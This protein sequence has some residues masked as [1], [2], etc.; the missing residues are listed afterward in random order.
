MK[1]FNKPEDKK[2]DLKR[3]VTDTSAIISG[4][5]RE[6]I[7]SGK[8]KN[9]E[10]IIPEIVMGELQAQTSRMRESGFLGLEEIKKIR[11]LTKKHKITL[12]F[13]G[14]RPSYED[15]LLAKSGR[16][17]AL[18]QDIAKQN[19]AVLITCDLPQALVAEA[20]GI[21]V[22][23]FESYKK[24]K[25][26]KIEKMLTNDTLSLHLKENAIPYAKKGKPGKIE[27]VKLKEK[28]MEAE[29]L[30]E[31]SN[32]IFEAARFEQNAFMEIGERSA[33]V[34]QLKDMRIAI[35]RPP[36][37]DG[38]EITVV[39]PIIKLNLNDYKLSKKLKER[40]D[41][42]V[43]GMLIAGP[44]GSGKSTLAASVAEF[45]MKNNNAIVKTM[46]SPRDL[47]LPNEITQ[48]APLDGSFIKTSDILLLVRP[49]YTIFDEVRK[50]KDF[51]V[52]ADMRLAGI[53]M[54]GVVHSTD[55]ISAVQ[56]FIG[57]IELGVIPHIVDTIL[58]VKDG[59]IKKVYS[60]SLT[61][62][63]PQGM[64]EADLA[65]PIVEVKDFETGK[66]EYEIYT[67]GEQTVVI[68]A[69][70]NGKKSGVERLALDKIKS[71][72]YK[73]D[74]KA[75]VE[76]LSANKISV[77]VR[78]DVI[79]Y[80]IGKEG[81]TIKNLED[82]LGISI[83]IEPAVESLG[84]E[85]ERNISETGGYLVFEFPK[86]HSGKNVNIYID[87]GYLFTATIGRSDQIKVSKKSDLGNKIMK[88]LTK[89]SEIK[90]FI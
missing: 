50:T 17:D 58:F 5:L 33:T 81:K 90:T 8:L 18:I 72:L 35:A 19:K 41:T 12:K 84:K 60:L 86:H 43:E 2:L 70:E 26:L 13:L 11:E 49:D 21:G 59:E 68:P 44:P 22:K 64:A 47:Q 51:E 10:I 52:F 78:N 85:I 6:M 30:E 89:K 48:Y 54:I 1:K 61:V 46:E 80:I 74:P 79:P 3:V 57:R 69:M 39:R 53:G 55:P 9:S 24:K 67:Y 88:A 45:L 16:V 65:R 23:Y 71:E 76:F 29:E 20:E 34:I 25:E 42:R 83:D 66:L 15:I 31:I 37:S 4:N 36:F 73:F 27:L 38:L 40:L 82:R 77:K 75:V 32:E 62:R 87:G 28:N 56:R 63:V 7:T 14:E